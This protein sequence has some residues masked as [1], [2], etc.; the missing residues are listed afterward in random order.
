MNGF[1]RRLFGRYEM[2]LGHVHDRITIR[3]GDETITLR[4]DEDARRIVRGLNE[5]QRRMNGIRG[6]STAE[7]QREVAEFFA[8]VIFGADQAAA[9]MDLYN[10]DAASV[11]EICG[12]YFSERL[13]QKIA[14]TQK[15]LK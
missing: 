14:K 2:S 8:G 13:A 4:V 11:I 15:R 12:E 6:E 3:E 7:E 1:I 10:G 9:L 5:A